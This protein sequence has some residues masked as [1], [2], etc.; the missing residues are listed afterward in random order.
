M[1]ELNIPDYGQFVIR[2]LVC[3]YSGTLG[4]EGRINLG[5]KDQLNQVAEILNIH[6]VTA[7]TFG[8]AQRGLLGVNCKLTILSNENQSAAKRDYVQQ[9]GAEQT[10]ALGSSRNDRLMLQTAA[11]GIAVLLEEG[12]AIQ[13]VQSADILCADISDALTYFTTPTRL[14]ATLRG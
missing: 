7:D 1:L 3:S 10:I 2:H 8:L 4:V 6:V 11:I 12:S 14:I 5:V 13:A 9:L